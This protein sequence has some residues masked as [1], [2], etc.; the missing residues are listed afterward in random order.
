MAFSHPDIHVTVLG[1][2][3]CVPSLKRSA[4]A[5]LARTGS[6]TLLFDAGPGTLRRL[7]EAGT[8]IFEVTH[9]FLSHFHPDHSAEVVPFLFATKYPDVSRRKHPLTIVAGKG[10]SNF[11]NGLK[12]VYG[13]WVVLPTGLLK[14]IEM[15]DT[16]PDTRQLDGVAVSSMPMAHNPESV[17]FRI[18]TRSGVA[19]V[20]SGDTDYT[21]NLVELARGA[22]LFICE[23]AL[24]DDL[25]V[26]GHLTP[27]LA[28]EVARKA[29]VSLMVL[30]HLYPECDLTDI[31][32]ECRKTYAGPMKIAHDLMTLEL[33]AGNPKTGEIPMT[34]PSTK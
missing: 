33:S 25:K 9:L 1:S 34:L 22:D 19:M 15:D 27:S 17:G 18:E 24:P 26:K 2:G 32:K 20:Y 3:T 28:G 10:L 30:T 31:E 12:K 4:C 8:T 29:G 6:E 7:L 11:Y 14:L 16:R 5:V 13:D 21:E 23:S